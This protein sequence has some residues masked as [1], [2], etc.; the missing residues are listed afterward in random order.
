MKNNNNGKEN[1]VRNDSPT[2]GISSS[3]LQTYGFLGPSLSESASSSSVMSPASSNSSVSRARC[4]SASLE[5]PFSR[6]MGLY[7]GFASGALAT[8]M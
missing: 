8:K 5:C 2:P 7:A 4:S 6:E 3:N 1:M